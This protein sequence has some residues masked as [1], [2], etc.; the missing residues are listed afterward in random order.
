MHYACDRVSDC[1][2]EVKILAD[3]VQVLLAEVA[4][5]AIQFCSLAVPVLNVAESRQRA[6][7]VGIRQDDLAGIG[8]DFLDEFEQQRVLLRAQ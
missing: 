6:G 7:E 3:T 8:M 2:V 1:L 5:L 4:H